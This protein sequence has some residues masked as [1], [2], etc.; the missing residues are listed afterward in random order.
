MD[1]QYSGEGIRPRQADRL[2]ILKFEVR[3]FSALQFQM[4]TDGSEQKVTA[5]VLNWWVLLME[6]VDQLTSASMS[7]AH[8]RVKSGIWR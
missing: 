5:A 3:Y 4:T 1:E 2:G 8:Q 7:S 6:V